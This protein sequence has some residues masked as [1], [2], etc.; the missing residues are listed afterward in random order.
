MNYKAALLVANMANTA[1]RMVEHMLDFDA[2]ALQR[3]PDL[4]DIFQRLDAIEE[5]ALALAVAMRGS[6]PTDKPV[7]L[8]GTSLRVDA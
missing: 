1:S 7:L 5:E 8:R 6:A 4:S 2:E 3:W